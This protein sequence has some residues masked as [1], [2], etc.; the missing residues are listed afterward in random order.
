MKSVLSDKCCEKKEK[1][2]P[3]LMINSPQNTIY[4]MRN[5]SCGVVVHCKVNTKEIGSSSTSLVE[6]YLEDY[7]GDVCLTND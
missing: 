5:S 2:F 3:K 7:E 4:L 6:R 1:P